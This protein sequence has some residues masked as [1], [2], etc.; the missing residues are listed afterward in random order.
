MLRFFSPIHP[1]FL[2]V[3]NTFYAADNNMVW[4]PSPP[5]RN[6]KMKN[7]VCCYFFFCVFIWSQ[8]RYKAKKFSFLNFSFN[9]PTFLYL[10]TLT[11][12][13]NFD[14]LAQTFTFLSNQFD[15]YIS[16]FWLP[17]LNILTSTQNL[18][19]F[20]HSFD[21]LSQDLSS[22]SQNFDS[23]QNFLILISQSKLENLREFYEVIYFTTKKTDMYE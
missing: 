23:I 12:S 20:P 2:F 3:V 9:L 13:H 14:V 18:D 22:S 17:Y 7:W 1:I 6:I 10:K 8:F 16:K 19:F 4:S 11:S 15:F 5:V 21:F